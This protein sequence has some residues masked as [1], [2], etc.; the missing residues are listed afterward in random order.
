MAQTM[1]YL[2]ER[3]LLDYAG[4][5]AKA[6]AASACYHELSDSIKAAETRTAEFAV[7]KTHIISYTKTRSVYVA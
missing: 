7:L 2:T 1:N 5:A 3:K 6:D 4:L